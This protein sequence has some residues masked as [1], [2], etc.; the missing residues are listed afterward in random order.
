MMITDAKRMLDYLKART[1]LTSEYLTSRNM[2]LQEQL[3]QRLSLRDMDELEHLTMDLH[4]AKES[5]LLA[6]RLSVEIKSL[7]LYYI[8]ILQPY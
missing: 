7:D 1:K 8:D 6:D 5:K 3:V 2:L 4:H